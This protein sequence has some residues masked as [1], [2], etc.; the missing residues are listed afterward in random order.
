MGKVEER[1]DILR[2]YY[3]QIET[4]FGFDIRE[5]ISLKKIQNA[6]QKF[7]SGVDSSSI[8]GFYDT[9]IVGSGKNGYLFTDEMVY[10]LEP[11]EKPK[12]LYYN[13][14]ERVEVLRLEKKD[15]D[16][17]LKFYMKDG[18]TITWT[19]CFLNKMSLCNFFEEI[20]NEK[21]SSQTENN[22]GRFHNPW[23]LVSGGFAA[24]NYGNVNKS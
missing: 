6:R 9:T 14:I 23:G 13:H 24:G 2:K 10:Y 16:R 18:T 12:K 1:A 7:A 4:S 15:C 8:I 21:H 3:K 22:Q 20:L 19:S 11:L 17:H 5:N